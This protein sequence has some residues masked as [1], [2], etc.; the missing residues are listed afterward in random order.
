MIMVICNVFKKQKS[1]YS[2]N[3]TLPLHH[4]EKSTHKFCEVQFPLYTDV[5]EYIFANFN[6]FSELKR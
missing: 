2:H 3:I 6:S 4:L 5:P 1:T